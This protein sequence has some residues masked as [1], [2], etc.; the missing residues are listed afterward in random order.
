MLS[1]SAA[2][3]FAKT[4]QDTTRGQQVSSVG[5]RFFFP[6]SIGL[7]VPF[8][9]NFINLRTGFAINAAIEY[10]PEYINAFFFRVDLDILGNN[11]TGQFHNEQTT[12]IIQGKLS[13]DF[14]LLGTGYRGKLG[15]WGL[16]GQVLPGL[17]MRSFDRATI[18][19]NG[20]IITRVTDDSFAAKTSLGVEYYL[21]KHFDIFFEPSFYKYFSHSGFDN[22]ARTQ[23]MSFNI[24]V[25]TARF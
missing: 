3:V 9:N 8:S 22:S 15:R 7:S 19:D 6:N 10:R 1:F 12:N 25:A 13:S 18:L 24:G 2:M 21:K 4:G 16:Y 5:S 23:M 17:G 20:V 14:I 11:Y